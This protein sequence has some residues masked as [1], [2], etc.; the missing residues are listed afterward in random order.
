MKIRIT[1]DRS[2]RLIW[3]SQE[4]YVEK[5]ARRF[6]LADEARGWPTTPLAPTVTLKPATKDD[7]LDEA[8]RLNY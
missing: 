6:E 4:Q 5:V 2:N 8:G 7:E 1:R 3:L